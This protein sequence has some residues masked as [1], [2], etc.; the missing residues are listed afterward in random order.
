VLELSFRIDR[1]HPANPEARTLTFELALGVD[2]AP[3]TVVETVLLHYYLRIE[4]QR[5]SYDPGARA[6]LFDLFGTPEQWARTLRSMA[7]TN[8]G[9][10]VPRFR[11]RTEVELPV[12]CPMD[13]R[14]AAAKY[15]GALE[16]GDVPLT[17]QFSG[18]VF[19][20]TGKSPIQ[21]SP[22]PR[23]AEA[24]FRLPVRVWKDLMGPFPETGLLDE[25]ESRRHP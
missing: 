21:V 18:T 12:A 25:F 17:F 23:E 8:G 24:T 9:V 15:F 10:I 11:G 4:P 19:H 2:E 5:R 7:W 3:D 1:V 6:R 16:E 14:E 13:G 20:A 22:I